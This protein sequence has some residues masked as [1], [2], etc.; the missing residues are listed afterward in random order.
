MNDGVK[1][2]MA[3]AAIAVFPRVLPLY[4]L[5]CLSAWTDDLYNAQN[6][7]IKA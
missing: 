6:V 2:A 4:E 7:S 5:L 1:S 3:L